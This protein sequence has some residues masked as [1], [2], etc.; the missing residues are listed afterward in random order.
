[1]NPIFV[2]AVFVW[3]AAL[4]FHAFAHG[5]DYRLIGKDA[6]VAAEFFYSDKTPMGYAEILIFSPDNETVEYQNGRTDQNGKFAFLA[7]TPG[8]W[9]IKVN[10]GMGH[11][12]HATV[13]VNPE[14]K[15]TSELLENPQTRTPKKNDPLFGD[16][17]MGVRL[18]FGLS[19]LL[20]LFLGVYVWKRKP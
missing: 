15:D 7:Q 17:P 11:A 19:I 5:T 20:N 6:V 2:C 8:N 1:M 12:V 18:V 10:D 9:N 4:P 14:S 3:I 13:T 16:T